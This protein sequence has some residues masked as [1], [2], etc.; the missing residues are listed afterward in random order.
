MKSIPIF[1]GVCFSL[2]PGFKRTLARRGPKASAADEQAQPLLL[3][4]CGNW[5]GGSIKLPFSASVYEVG[6]DLFYPKRSRSF[7]AEEREAGLL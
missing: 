4:L 1:R 6:P 5:G 2:L 7:E 3:P